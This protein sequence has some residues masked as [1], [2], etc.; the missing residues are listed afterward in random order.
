VRRALTGL[1]QPRRDDGDLAARVFPIL[2][3]R[4]DRASDAPL[5]LALSGGGDSMALLALAADW[6]RD[7]GRRLIAFTVDHGLQP[8]SARW[9][10]FAGAAARDLG[11][12]WRPLAWTGAKPERGV[13]A[14]ARRARHALI[15][16]AAR[17]EGARVV[18]F[19]H[20]ADDAAE[21]ALMRQTEG[22]NLGDLRAWSPSPVWPHGRDVFLLR[23]LLQVRRD[24]L[25]RLL[26]AR[27]LAWIEDPANED[28][29]FA[30]VR[31][32]RRLAAG[33]TPVAAEATAPEEV[34]R[35]AASAARVDAAG[36]I[37]FPRS[38]ALPGGVLAAALLCASG[39]DE[40]PRGEPLRRLLARLASGERFAATLR[41]ARI[42]ADEGAVRILRDAG[43]TARG[44]L[45]PVTLEPG[46]AS[47]W[48]GRFEVVH[49]AAAEIHALKGFAAGLNPEDR[50]EIRRYAAAARPALPAL[51]ESPGASPVLATAKARVRCLVGSRFAAACGLVAHEGKIVLSPRGEAPAASLC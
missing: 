43:E 5:A 44:G 21:N 15:A 35:A 23:P 25:R 30:R 27:G 6:A 46:R 41:G 11:V 14:A 48:D 13:P 49:A 2:D 18:L 37:T 19:A 4:L 7:A 45:S 47:I 9:T 17:A 22:S 20:T 10:A 31:A 16:E 42:E 38:T 29:R 12:D 39:G 36:V 40:P 1:R 8:E 24:A 33:E 3:L 50:E 51:V 26:A 34:L 28:V 32:R